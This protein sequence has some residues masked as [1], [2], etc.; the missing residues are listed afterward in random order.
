MPIY[1]FYCEDCDSRF[2]T[3]VRNS[4]EVVTCRHCDSSHLKKLI[5]TYAISSGSPDTP[6]GAAPCSPAPACGGGT[7]PSSH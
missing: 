7:C 6:C 1:E 2:E 4:D 3:L 5:S